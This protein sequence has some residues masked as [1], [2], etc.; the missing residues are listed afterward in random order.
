MA[1]IGQNWLHLASA[2]IYFNPVSVVPFTT[3][4]VLH[5]QFNLPYIYLVCVVLA[6]PSLHSSILL[7]DIFINNIVLP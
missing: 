5:L 2:R 7:E 3:R 1:Y 4:V 6:L